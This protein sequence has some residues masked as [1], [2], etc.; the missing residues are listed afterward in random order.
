MTEAQQQQLESQLK[1]QWDA[2]EMVGA[3]THAIEAYGPE[4]LGYL[5]AV[6]RN[7]GDAEEAFSTFCEALWKE[8]ERFRWECS[9]RTWAYALARHAASHLRRAPHRRPGRA[10]PLSRSPEVYEVAQRVRTATLEFL[11]TSTKDRF[12]RLREQLDPEDQTLFILRLNRRMSWNDIARIM[13]RDAGE[14]SSEQLSRASASLRKRFERAKQR[15]R[16]L[17]IEHELIT[18]SDE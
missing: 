9:F 8:I 11:R 5:V 1:Q 2:G 6:L 4:I 18:E 12:A 7:H 3:A 13:S 14:L 15:L 10:I 17:A 16:Q